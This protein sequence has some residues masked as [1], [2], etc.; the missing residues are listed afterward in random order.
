MA[1]V[2]SL[3]IYGPMLLIYGLCIFGVAWEIGGVEFFVAPA[4]A[5]GLVA[6]AAVPF[7][8]SAGTRSKA[9]AT[10]VVAG[11]IFLLFIPAVGVATS[12][13]SYGFSR[14]TQRA[15]PL[16]AAIEKYV[17]KEGRAPATL[18][19]LIPHYLQ[20]LPTGLPDLEIITGDDARKGYYGNEWVLHAVVPSGI[21]N[22]D[23]FLYFPNQLYPEDGYGGWLERIERWAYVHE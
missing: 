6:F 23:R 5:S 19:A 4:M 8:M 17:E 12:L 13:R 22:W 7:L 21:I 2:G 16:I 9:F 20:A 3:A 10:V 14:A 18:Q 11:I 1:T 15:A